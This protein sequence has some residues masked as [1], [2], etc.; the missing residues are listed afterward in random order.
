[1][2]KLKELLEIKPFWRIEAAASRLLSKHFREYLWL[3]AFVL[4]FID[5]FRLGAKSGCGFFAAPPTAYWVGT[6]LILL[7]VTYFLCGYSWKE[8]ICISLVLAVF[9][10]SYLMTGD[11]ALFRLAVFIFSARGIPFDRICKF[12]FWSFLTGLVIVVTLSFFGVTED[13]VIVRSELV[14]RGAIRHSLGFR[15]PNGLGL[16]LTLLIAARLTYTY[17][18]LRIADYIVWLA[19]TA[20][21]FIVT[22]SKLSLML[23]VL[24]L[25]GAMIS[26]HVNGKKL[27]KLLLICIPCIAAAW[28]LLIFAYDSDSK[29]L[30]TINVLTSDRVNLARLA[31]DDLG[32]TLLGQRISFPL[33]VDSTFASIPVKNGLAAFICLILLTGYSVKKAYQSGRPELMILLTGYVLYAVMETSTSAV[34]FSFALIAL[35]ADLGSSSA[36]KAAF[37]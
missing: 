9:G 6:L 17:K 30:Y 19:A 29:L 31:Y 23:N 22:N 1:M 4:Q 37:K 28:M 14:G 16:C 35:A 34:P 8:L 20:V 11:A 5:T 7:A 32:V 25:V 36:D 21:C 24:M 18:K 3:C 10:L 12:G 27:S 33:P 15:N 26:K 2:R 13:V